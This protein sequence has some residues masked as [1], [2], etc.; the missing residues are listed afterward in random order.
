MQNDDSLRFYLD[1]T[2]QEL[3]KDICEK[4]NKSGLYDN[5][6]GG[7]PLYSMVRGYVR[8]RIL[9]INGL[10][11]MQ[12]K[13]PVKGWAVFKSSIVSF[14]HLLKLFV[15]RKKYSSIYY[16]FARVDKV[17]DY[18]LD[19]FTDPIIEQCEKKGSYVI[20]DYGRAGVHAKP[21]IHAESIVYL[22]MISA[23]ARI[24]GMLF[25]QLYYLRYKKEFDS[26]F[27]KLD[28]LFGH[29]FNKSYIIREYVSNRVYIKQLQKLFKR[30]SAKRVVGPARAFMAAPFI[31]A[32]RQ[33]M[34]TFELQHGVS[35][36]E[37][38]LYSGYRDEMILPDF[39]LAFGDNKPLDV[40]GIDESHIINIG[41]A[42]QDYVAKTIGNNTV[43]EEDVLVV[44]DPEITDAIISAVLKLAKDFPESTF[45]IR[46]HPHEVITEQQRK[47][48][49]KEPNVMIQDNT[50]NITVA[51]HRFDQIIGENSTVLYEA[52]AVNKKVG[53]LF[54]EGLDPKYLVEEDRE[55]FWEIK[56]Q[57]DFDSFLNGKVEQKRSKCIYS[58]FDKNNYLKITGIAE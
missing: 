31:A 12:L 29:T 23:S 57:K 44:S 39:F 10:S 21:R 37:T 20:L 35:Y 16:A 18:F 34:Q 33:G 30:V 9:E 13:S 15:S 46:P 19:K 54:F 32:K 55:C 22:D 58:P 45:Y 1:M 14:G 3:L 56:D 49:A 26:F 38:V 50:I 53:K 8:Y 40:Y 2:E 6:I 11:F 48:I 4:E 51:L 27:E 43:R 5:N 47:I 17:G 7:L 42:F 41:W 28:A 24:Y 52:L 36:G 25:S